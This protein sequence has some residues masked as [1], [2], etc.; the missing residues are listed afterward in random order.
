[1]CVDVHS[2]HELLARQPDIIGTAKLF[3]RE[4]VKW[5]ESFISIFFHF[6]FFSLYF[7][8]EDFASKMEESYRGEN[9]LF[10]SHSQ[11]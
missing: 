1:V 11:S 2:V 7:M 3:W 9:S 5:R 10:K 8:W 4:R 6:P